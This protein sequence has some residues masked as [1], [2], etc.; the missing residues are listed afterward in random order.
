MNV[1]G[2]KL[3]AP[4]A[5]RNC[6]PILAALTKILPK[7]GTVLEIAS[8]SGQH[9]AAFAQQLPDLTWQPSEP[10]PRNRESIRAYLDESGLKNVLAPLEIDVTTDHD[11]GANYAAVTCINMIHI[12]PWEA[13]LGLLRNA[14]NWLMPGGLLYLYGPFRRGGQHTAP[15]NAA[16]DESLRGQNPAW[17]VRDLDEIALLAEAHSF[18]APKLEQMPAN[19]L[20]VWLEKQ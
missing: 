15:S 10:N 14:E 18:A 13:T 16:F 6:E 4:A 3:H 19:N 5:E 7:A 11:L 1:P 12:A 8:G 20:S 2:L 17:G 9:I